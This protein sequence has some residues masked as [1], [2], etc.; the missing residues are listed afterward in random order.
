MAFLTRTDPAR[1]IDR[2]YIVEIMPSLFGDW[3]VLREWAGADPPAPSGSIATRA[4]M[5]P[6][7]P[8]ARRLSCCHP[9]SQA[10][11]ISVGMSFT[12]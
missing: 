9:R 7:P 12:S 1:N 5:K 2:F 6:R 11:P 3:T 8:S 10:W 4:G